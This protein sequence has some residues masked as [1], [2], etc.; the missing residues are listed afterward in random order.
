[1][2]HVSSKT[3][4][5]WLVAVSLLLCTVLLVQCLFWAG[6]LRKPQTG[7]PENSAE[8][9]ASVGSLSREGYELEQ[10]V[11]LSRHNIRSPLSGAGS[12]LGTITPHEWFSWSS[13]PSEL[14]LRGGVLETEM[15]QYFRVWLISEGLFPDNYF[16]EDGEVRIY[17]NS[18]QRTIATAEYFVSGLLPTANFPIETHAEYDQMDPVFNPQLTFVSP[19]YNADAESQ[20]RELYT[21]TIESL[22]DNYKLLSDVIDMEQ[23]EAWSSGSVGALRLDDTELFF[24]LHKEPYMGGSLKTACSVSDALILQY[25]EEADPVKAGFGH[26]LSEEQWKQ[27]A[28]VKDIYGDVL[29]TAPLIAANVANPLLRE[30][31]SELTA[32]SRVFTFLCGHDS[33]VGS[34]LAAL[35][36]EDYELPYAIEG[37]TPIGCK[38]VFCRWRGPDGNKYCTVDMVYQTVEQLRAAPLLD[39]NRH[40][41]VVPIYFTDLNRTENGM[42]AE[43][44]FMELLQNAI[45]EYDRITESYTLD[46]AA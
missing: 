19:D 32:D 37:K 7:L 17:A 1:M 12:T 3:L 25:Y 16:P 26:S 42:Y 27:I 18:K 40:P 21:D 34:V 20:V 2:N 11:V 38:L 41:S 22:A 9:F 28:E 44:D 14:S 39:L 36:A 33:N 13:N 15:G 30:I 6:A 45:G 43:Q 35:G 46:N 29:F 5:G 23:S 24:E 4:R 10:T 31:K 8:P